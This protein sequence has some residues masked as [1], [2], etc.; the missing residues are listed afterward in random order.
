MRR[1]PLSVLLAVLSVVKIEGKMCVL[2]IDGGTAL[3]F[4]LSMWCCYVVYLSHIEK[5]LS[6]QPQRITVVQLRAYSYGLTV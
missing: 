3:L 2:H 1:K 5:L 6:A 4:Q